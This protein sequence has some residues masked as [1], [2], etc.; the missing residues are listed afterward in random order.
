MKALFS[1]MLAV[2]VEVAKAI[3]QIIREGFYQKNNVENKGQM[4]LLLILFCLKRKY[5]LLEQRRS[6]DHHSSIG[7]EYGMKKDGAGQA[8]WGMFT[9]ENS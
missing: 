6:Y 5:Y 8:N 1:D 4:R 7:R 3:G 9:D 2:A